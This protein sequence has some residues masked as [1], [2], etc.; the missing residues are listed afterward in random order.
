MQKVQ[1]IRDKLK[2]KYAAGDFTTDKSGSKTVELI[3]E[4]FLVDEPIIF[5]TENRDYINREIKWYMSQSRNVN[6]IEGDVPKIWQMVSDKDGKINSNYGWCT[7]SKENNEQFKKVLQTLR[8][9]RDSR[10]AVMIYTRPTMHE[11]A[12]E[13]G[14]SDFICTNTVQYLIRN[15]VMNVIVQMRSNDVVFGFKNDYAWQKY[16]AKRLC[17]QLRCPILNIIWHVGSLHVYERHFKFLE[18]EQ[19]M[20]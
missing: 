12:F 13:N 14:M 19:E 3:G 1:D 2:A 8:D 9:N 10:Q 11:D 6:D 4:T 18:N 16:N 17:H 7:E 20:G 15:N 5:G